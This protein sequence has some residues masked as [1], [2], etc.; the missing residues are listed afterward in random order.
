MKLKIILAIISV[1]VLVGGVIAGVILVRQ[2]QL[3][4][5][6]AAPATSLT[7]VSS[8]SS[9]AVGDTFSVNVNID[10]GVNTVIGTELYIT[11]DQNKL[12]LDSF[13]LGSFFVNPNI[14][15][16]NIDNAIGNATYILFLPTG[17]IPLSGQGVVVSLNMQAVAGGVAS[18]GLSPDTLVAAIG[19]DVGTNVLENTNPTSVTVVSSQPVSSP[20][21]TPTSGA[22]FSPSATVAPTLTSIPTPIPTSPG[23]GGVSTPTP[24]VSSPTP[25]S[26]AG[27]AGSTQVTLTSVKDGQVVSDTTPTF[28][29]TAS[30]NATISITISSPDEIK[31][32]VKASSTGTWTF[33]PTTALTAGSHTATIIATSTTGATSTTSVDFT[34]SAAELPDSGISFPT[35]LGIVFGIIV[36]TLSG[37]LLKFASK[38]T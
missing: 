22:G 34:V 13:S 20:T 30:P 38:G 28:S 29:G 11:F 9:P 14:Q 5:K 10:T 31:G 2:R 15:T 12:Q 25:T 4:T 17:T 19:G 23:T 32:T 26:T 7:L 33:T 24:T 21:P 16:Q 37:A 27:S 1:I 3:L 6:Q 36:L 18:I 8:N 35:I